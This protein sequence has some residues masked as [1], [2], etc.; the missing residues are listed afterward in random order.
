MAATPT[1]AEGVKP[2]EAASPPARRRKRRLKEPHPLRVFVGCVISGLLAMAVCYYGLNF[3]RGEEYDFLGIY[4]PGVP[5]T[6]KYWKSSPA[7]KPQVK[8]PA[9]IQP[10][11]PPHGKTLPTK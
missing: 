7:V 9:G 11:S 6:Y 5:H 10:K 3:F 1:A 2:V 8:P 4:L